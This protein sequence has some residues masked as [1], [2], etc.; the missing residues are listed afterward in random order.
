MLINLYANDLSNQITERAQLKHFGD[1]CRPFS[2]DCESEIAPNCLQKNIVK[3]KNYLFFNRW[4]L[5][6]N[7]LEF[8]TFSRKNGNRLQNSETVV[9]G[10]SMIEKPNQCKYLGV[11]I[12]TYLD[13]QTETKE[14]MNK[15][16]V[17]TKTIETIQH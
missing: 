8:I 5:E 12:D 7:K 14:V 3:L 11:A 17:G 16:A 2:S 9:V 1:D 4:N 15:M 13:F 10:S 6:D